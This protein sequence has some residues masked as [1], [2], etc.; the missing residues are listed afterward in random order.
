M[1]CYGAMYVSMI[2]VPSWQKPIETLEEIKYLAER[3]LILAVS[4][5]YI[6]DIAMETPCCDSFEYIL[7]QNM[8]RYGYKR[9][10]STNFWKKIDTLNYYPWHKIN[11]VWITPRIILEFYLTH[12]TFPFH[13]GKKNLYIDLIGIY[14]Q[15]DAL[16][17]HYFSNL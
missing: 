8:Q 14:H 17:N 13:I 12:F 16:Y 11:L 9:N 3:D 5:R 1:K 10:L 2:T 4:S 7:K 6:Y 15:K